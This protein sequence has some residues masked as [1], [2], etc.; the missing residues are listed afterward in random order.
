MN[1]P[2]LLLCLSLG[3]LSLVTAQ[4]TFS[5]R[6]LEE[7][8]QP[9]KDA[10]VFLLGPNS[11]IESTV[12]TDSLGR[13]HLKEVDFG[14]ELLRVTAFGYGNRDI[15]SATDTVVVL[16][17][18]GVDLQE[19]EVQAAARVEQKNDR[20]VFNVAN[21]SL[22]KASS[23]SFELLKMAPMIEDKNDRLSILG[24]ESAELYINGRKSNLTQE[25]MRAY[26]QSLPADRIANIEV[27]TNPGVT[28]SIDANKGIINLVL[29]KNEAD[30]VKGSLSLE[31]T[32]KKLNSQK[33]SLYLDVQKEKFNM[34]ANIYGENNQQKA[35]STTEYYYV[36]SQKYDY[37]NSKNRDQYISGG[38]NLRMDYNLNPNHTIGAVVDYFYNRN[39]YKKDDVTKYF[40]NFV[41][42]YIDSIYHSWNKDRELT[43]RISANVNYRAK[44]SE[45]DNLSIDFDYFW[46][47]KEHT[48]FNDFNREDVTFI[49]HQQFNERSEE[50]FNN[51]SGKVEYSHR[52]NDAHSLIGGVEFSRTDQDADF[53]H[54]DI[55]EGVQTP[56]LSKNNHFDYNET[57][58]KGY[59]AWN[60]RFGNKWM[61]NAGVRLENSKIE[62]FQQVTGKTI[63]RKDFD[64]VPNLSVMFVPNPKHQLNYNFMNVIERPGF[65]SLNPFRFYINP[66][67]YKEYNSSLEVSKL[68]IQSLSY[69]LN[70][71]YIF[72]VDYLFADNASNDFYVPVDDK[73]TK[74]INANYGDRH[75]LM[76]KFI[77][78]QDFFNKRLFINTS[79]MGIY[80][81]SKGNVESVIIDSEGVFGIFSVNANALLSPQYNWSLSFSGNC[82]TVTKGGPHEDTSDTYYFN[83]SVQKIFPK[84]I[85][86]IIGG[87]F[88]KPTYTREKEYSNYQYYTKTDIDLSG[89]FIKLTIP[90]GNMKTKG[91]ENRG[92]SS[93]S[94][95]L[96]EN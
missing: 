58:T 77:W 93:S 56:D 41:T 80:Q 69:S 6:V 7:N 89:A 35:N 59:L 52:F 39:T 78:N 18:L 82:R 73:Y 12:M 87:Y 30:G 54:V 72:V 32:Q 15:T 9:V 3:S 64:I 83:L 36:E 96:K 91:A 28:N 51:Y 21:T 27:I 49:S 46:N 48:V 62:G 24:K 33:G 17:P 2:I 11:V 57:L 55:F 23:S 81:R 34:T 1:K 22:A 20:F 90:F 16:K 66:N 71:K 43:N 74:L 95:R 53:S 60:W 50:M 70:N 47:K 63:D 68:Y 44:L 26:L 76:L 38:G 86:L 75:S 67:T 19:V 8:K 37:G 84:D 10:I 79:A 94:S 85:R 5:G 65:Y 4:T 40:S 14:R 61:G 42:N 25:A 13:F 31:D 29:K 88:A 45:Q 92:T